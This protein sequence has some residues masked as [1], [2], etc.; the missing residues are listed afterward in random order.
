MSRRRPS[1]AVDRA[2]VMDFLRQSPRPGVEAAPPDP[3]EAKSPDAGP[4]ASPPTRA[5]GAARAAEHSKKEKSEKRELSHRV[6]ATFQLPASVLDQARD[7]VVAL[8][9]RGLTLTRL[10][11]EAI[12]RELTRLRKDLNGGRPFPPRAVPP[13]V[14]RPVSR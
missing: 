8:S 10:F 13:R 5:R 12:L 4:A 7:A 9:P 14:G 1:L 11:E 6:R 2:D 3:A